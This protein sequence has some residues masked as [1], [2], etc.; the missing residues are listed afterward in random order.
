MVLVLSRWLQRCWLASLFQEVAPLTA[1]TS[2]FSLLGWRGAW[3]SR[4]RASSC[5]PS[6]PQPFLAL[7]S[8][9]V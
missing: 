1:P 5:T 9:P 3:G 6:A 8:A 2:D 7:L 4:S